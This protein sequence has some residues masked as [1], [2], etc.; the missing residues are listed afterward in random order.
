MNKNQ[1]LQS[2]AFISLLVLSLCCI[3]Y[4][5]EWGVRCNTH[6]ESGKINMLMNR[7]I[8]PELMIF[9]SSVALVQL[10]DSLIA[11]HTGMTTVNMGL[12]GVSFQQYRGLAEEFV[13]YTTKCK[14]VVFVNTPFELIT[15]NLLYEAFN[16]YAHIGNEAIYNSLVG[17]DPMLVNKM[18]YIPLYP[19]T[20]YDGH[21]Y[22]LSHE[23]HKE[24]TGTK[25][26]ATKPDGFL[27]VNDFHF[28]DESLRYVQ[29]HS[30]HIPVNDTLISYFR[31]IISLYNDKGIKVIL[32]SPPVEQGMNDRISN[33]EKLAATWKKLAGAKN[34]FI[35]YSTDSLSTQRELF[36]NFTH[37]NS[38]GA[39]IFSLR[40][41]NDL[42]T[43][44]R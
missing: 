23:G 43:L 33:G 17:I 15:R 35:D 31:E 1:L 37:L 4:Y 42:K 8:D 25:P 21:F 36:Y 14:Y 24:R 16:F 12:S 30:L 6:G 26:H 27:P 18:R 32:L 11:S 34:Y 10:D 9:G 38:K 29:N 19:L 13:S 28:N 2:A 40:F 7:Q 5:V 44:V 20:V 41:A 3:Q 39:R 22:R